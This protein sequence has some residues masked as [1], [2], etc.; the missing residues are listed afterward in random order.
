MNPPKCSF[1]SV[2][3]GEGSRKQGI[4]SMRRWAGAMVCES[5]VAGVS[6]IAIY[7]VLAKV[8]GIKGVIT[9][10]PFSKNQGIFFVESSDIANYLREKRLILVREKNRN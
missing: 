10:M 3:V 6:R 1:A 2:V 7:R 4:E 9:I 5:S 8:V